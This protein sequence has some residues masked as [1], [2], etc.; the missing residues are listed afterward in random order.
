MLTS[1]KGSAPAEIHAPPLQID[2]PERTRPTEDES[3]RFSVLILM[4]LCMVYS[5][6]AERSWTSS[7]QVVKPNQSV[8]ASRGQ[9]FLPPL[10]SPAPHIFVAVPRMGTSILTSCSLPC[11]NDYA[12]SSGRPRSTMSYGMNRVWWTARLSSV[13]DDNI[14]CCTF[15]FF[16]TQNYHERD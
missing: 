9:P 8:G 4:L 16:P 11:S 1:R 2:K 3:G 12:K 14:L 5:R 7:K 13:G 10:S 15:F 6:H